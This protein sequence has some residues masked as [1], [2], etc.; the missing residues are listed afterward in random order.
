MIGLK[1]LY[2]IRTLIRC[3]LRVSGYTG[4]FK[5]H[6]FV[7][8]SDLNP[9]NPPLYTGLVLP[10][11]VLII[12]QYIYYLFDAYLK[13]KSVLTVGHLFPENQTI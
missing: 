2:R 11:N 13:S 1:K 8:G 9:Q 12:T 3:F 4:N 5:V 6:F 7:G 10:T